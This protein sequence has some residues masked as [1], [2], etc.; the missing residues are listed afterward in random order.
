MGMDSGLQRAGEKVI[1]D[2]SRAIVGLIKRFFFFQT[3]ISNKKYKL[4]NPSSFYL[5][6]L[7]RAHAL[8]YRYEYVI[9]E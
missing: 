6:E 5:A 7:A 2:I 9:P 8:S 3:Q 4:R 1:T